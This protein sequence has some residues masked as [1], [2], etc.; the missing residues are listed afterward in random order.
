MMVGE[1]SWVPS[2]YLKEKYAQSQPKYTKKMLDL[3]FTLVVAKSIENC[4]HDL[5]EK[6]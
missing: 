2:V 3:A 4:L 5:M 1:C 6:R